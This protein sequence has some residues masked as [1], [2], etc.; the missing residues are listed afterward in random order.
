MIVKVFSKNVSLWIVFVSFAE[1]M[2][3]CVSFLCFRLPDLAF[4]YAMLNQG[5]LI[6]C[7]LSCGLIHPGSAFMLTSERE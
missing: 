6:L 1:F 4:A 7:L 3:L 2:C 5:L